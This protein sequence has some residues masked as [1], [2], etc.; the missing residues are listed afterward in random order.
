M[1]SAAWKRTAAARSRSS[2]MCGS[3][4]GADHDLLVGHAEAHVLGQVGLGALKLLERRGRGLR[5]LDLAVADEARGQVR[6]HGA[7][8][9]PPATW[10]A[11]R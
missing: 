6:A 11:A 4:S 3:S 8:D 7:R 1:A 2:S 10:T 9:A 5:V